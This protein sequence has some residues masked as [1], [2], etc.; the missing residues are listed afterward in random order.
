MLQDAFVKN[1]L[2]KA[3]EQQYRWSA[4]LHSGEATKIQE[5]I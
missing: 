5:K 1:N 3:I 2:L 4:Q